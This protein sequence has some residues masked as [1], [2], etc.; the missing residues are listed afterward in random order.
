MQAPS[1]LNKIWISHCEKCKICKNALYGDS[2]QT[3]SKIHNRSCKIGKSMYKNFI[4][5]QLGSDERI[6]ETT[7]NVK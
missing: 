4:I 7:C 1:E 3:I 5:E 6:A 2:H